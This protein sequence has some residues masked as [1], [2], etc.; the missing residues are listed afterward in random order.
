MARFLHLSRATP[1]PPTLCLLCHPPPSFHFTASSP[2]PAD[3]RAQEG[4]GLLFAA[5]A[6]H[7]PVTQV[8]T[9][10]LSPAPELPAC[11]GLEPWDLCP[12]Q[13]HQQE[14][15]VAA[16]SGWQLGSCLEGERDP[17]S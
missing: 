11:R 10:H 3:S 8:V 13:R 17:F 12:E 15:S 1:L 4:A 14:G 9:F 16:E 2:G 6:G 7:L 5:E